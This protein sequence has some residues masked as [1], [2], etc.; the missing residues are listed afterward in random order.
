M[1]EL[2]ILPVDPNFESS[3]DKLGVNRKNREDLHVVDVKNWIAERNKP[4]G[5]RILYD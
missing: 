2:Y 5:R 4:Y 1:E 3:L